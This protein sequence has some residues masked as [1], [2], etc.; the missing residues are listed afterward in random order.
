MKYSF[1]QTLINIYTHNY[2][3]Q[4]KTIFHN[5]HGAVGILLMSWQLEN[6]AKRSLNIS[7]S[8][9]TVFV[10]TINNNVYSI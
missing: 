10:L 2:T 1:S 3:H 4:H 8:L 6:L 7:N 9:L 5:I